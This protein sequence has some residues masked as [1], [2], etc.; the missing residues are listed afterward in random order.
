MKLVG[1]NINYGIQTKGESFNKE[2]M[3]RRK[4]PVWIISLS[5]IIKVF[6]REENLERER[7]QR[8]RN[9]PV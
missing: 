5:T 6:P 9:H 7:Q 1:E 3:R 8:E 4:F 2:P